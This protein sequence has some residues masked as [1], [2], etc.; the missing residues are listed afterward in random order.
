MFFN[1][2]DKIFAQ[3]SLHEVTV[4][5]VHS[6]LWKWEPISLGN[7]GAPLLEINI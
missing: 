2:Q 3:F 5:K 1:A 4:N 6:M 7:I